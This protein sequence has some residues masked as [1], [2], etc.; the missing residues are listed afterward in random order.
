MKGKE[1]LDTG[2]ITQL[3]AKDVPP[4]ISILMTSV[5]VEKLIA[6]VKFKKFKECVVSRV[7]Y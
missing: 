1:C 6:Y 7:N 5:K 3:Y 4:P 2:I